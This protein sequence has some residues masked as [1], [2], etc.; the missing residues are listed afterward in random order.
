VLFAPGLHAGDRIEFSAS[1]I[2]LSVPKPE[3]EIKAPERMNSASDLAPDAVP[4]FTGEAE[5]ASAMTIVVA[6]PMAKAKVGWDSGNSDNQARK[7]PYDDPWDATAPE[8]SLWTNDLSLRRGWDSA[9]GSRLDQ[10]RGAYALDHIEDSRLFGAQK[11]LDRNATRRENRLERTFSDANDSSF[12]STAYNRHDPWALGRIRDGRFNPLMDET[13][14]AEIDAYVPAAA[15][16]TGPAAGR[17]QSSA[18]PADDESSSFTE[19]NLRRQTGEQAVAPLD[20]MRAWDAPQ[21]VAGQR[22]RSNPN[23]EQAGPSRVVAA[24]NKPAVLPKPKWPG[25]PY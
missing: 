23:R 18:G 1:A 19:P 4:E 12:L 13:Q 7:D 2:P 17:L 3:K 5:M 20:K 11:E 6:R 8:P 22:A 15:I 24:P 21:S 25:N 9:A 16:K 10:R 14:S